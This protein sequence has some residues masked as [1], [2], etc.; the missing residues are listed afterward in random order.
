MKRNYYIFSSGKLIRKENTLY[1]EPGKSE[2]PIEAVKEEDE[3]E[4]EDESISK[5]DSVDEYEPKKLPRKPLPVEDIDS[6]YCFSELRFNTKFL[7]AKFYKISYLSCSSGGND[8][9]LRFFLLEH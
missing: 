9:V 7:K 6:I 4:V 2:D 1:F 5:E 3:F 8:I